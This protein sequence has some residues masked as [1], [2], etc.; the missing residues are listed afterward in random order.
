MNSDKIDKKF[1]P[2][3]R[4]IEFSDNYI[5]FNVYFKVLSYQNKE[6]LIDEFLRK[7]KERYDEENVIW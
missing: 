2:F 4:F 5:R 1:K 6:A 7:L 3:L